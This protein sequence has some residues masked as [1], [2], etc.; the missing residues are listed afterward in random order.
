MH[1]CSGVV[2]KTKLPENTWTDTALIRSCHRLRE[3]CD[4]SACAELLWEIDLSIVDKPAE[5]EL[6]DPHYQCQMVLPRL[7]DPD[8]GVRQ[9]LMVVNAVILAKSCCITFLVMGSTNSHRR[10]EKKSNHLNVGGVNLVVLRC[11]RSIEYRR[12]VS[13]LHIH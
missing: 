2:A 8:D 3:I 12:G 4:V 13:A 5:R 7:E 9:H 11:L 6:V 10:T 1:H